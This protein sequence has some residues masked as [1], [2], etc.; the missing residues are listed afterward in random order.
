MNVRLR[1]S[2]SIVLMSLRPGAR[3]ADSEDEGR[4]RPWQ[5]RH[6]NRPWGAAV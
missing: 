4:A 2:E 3:C 1:N 6:Q 5:R